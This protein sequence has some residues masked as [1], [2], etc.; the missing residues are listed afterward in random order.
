VPRPAADIS[1]VGRACRVLGVLGLSIGGLSAALNV[2][3]YLVSVL[4]SGAAGI[5]LVRDAREVGSGALCFLAGGGLQSRRD[6]GR[7][8][9]RNAAL[10]SLLFDL[11][12]LLTAVGDGGPGRLLSTLGSFALVAYACSWLAAETSRISSRPMAL[13][14]TSRSRT[15]SP[16]SFSSSSESLPLQALLWTSGPDDKGAGSEPVGVCPSGVAPIGRR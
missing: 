9:A 4:P 1:G 7:R 14:L 3:L 2:Y 8:L 13:N 6:W 10:V 5:G 16:G 15:A 11:R 12:T